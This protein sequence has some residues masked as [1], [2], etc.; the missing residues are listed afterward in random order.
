MAASPSKLTLAH[1]LT[2]TPTPH[3]HTVHTTHTTHT[4]HVVH[5]V[6]QMRAFLANG[7][8]MA[9]YALVQAMMLPPVNGNGK[10]DR[11]EL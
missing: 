5:T 1:T 3:P 10:A 7:G 9:I 2:L 4:G 11:R 8:G 6:H